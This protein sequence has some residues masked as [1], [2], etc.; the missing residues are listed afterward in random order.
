MKT[1]DPKKLAQLQKVE[2]MKMRHRAVP[3]DPR[4]KT[5]S[6]ALDQRLHVRVT[7]DNSDQEKVFWF[8]KSIGAGKALD[9]IATHFSLS[10][11][12]ARPLRL[13]KRALESDE[14][15]SLAADKELAG[16]VEEGSQLILARQT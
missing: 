6:V 16:Q 9:C 10:F 11:S 5:A 14:R 4:D 1:K 8:R 2:L 3:G 12:D 13:C 15:E 7:L